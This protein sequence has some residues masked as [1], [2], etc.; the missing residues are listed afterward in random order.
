VPLGQ[1]EIRGVV[2]WVESGGTLVLSLGG[3]TLAPLATYGNAGTPGAALAEAFGVRVQKWPAT[4]RGIRPRG[5]LEGRGIAGVRFSGGRTLDG[6]FVDQ[7][8]Y[9]TLVDGPAGPVVGTAPRGR[10]RVVAFA[11]DTAFTNRLLRAPSNA[12]MMVHLLAHYGRPGPILFDERHQGYGAEREAVEKLAGAL[13]GTGLG[14]ALLQGVL[15]AGALLLFAGRRFGSP[16][17]PPRARR[18]SA[19]EAAAALGRAYHEAGATALA[20]GTLA[21]G[22]RRRAA[23]R[24]G[25]PPTLDPA[26]FSDRLRRSRAPG[27]AEL[28]AALDRA[29]AVEGAGRAAGRAL[30]EAARDLERALALVGGRR[31]G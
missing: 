8:R 5:W 4:E 28:A 12:Q 11:D 13:S 21:A 18:R 27:A 19:T 15:A 29:G 3:G 6:P 20:A 14:L 23:L 2:R 25:I 26:E 16:L 7:P 24:L 22:A 1:D 30:A 17:P 10:G 9:Q 31:G